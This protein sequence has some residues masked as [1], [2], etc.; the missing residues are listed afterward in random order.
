MC[1]AASEMR[2]ISRILLV[3]TL[4][5]S[6][7]QVEAQSSGK[8]ESK[9]DIKGSVN[10]ETQKLTSLVFNNT[11][12]IRVLLP[13]GYH[14]PKNRETRYPVLYLNDGVMVF[15]AFDIEKTVH[16]LIKARSIPPMVVVGIDNGGSTNTTKDPIADRANEFLP[17]PDVGFAPDN[18]YEPT[19][20]N[21]AGKKYP[22]FLSEVISLAESRYR[23][24]TGPA[25]TGIGGF[26]YGG[27]AAIYAVLNR[28]GPFGK[29]LIESTPLWI[30]K[31]K[32]FMKDIESST[33]WPDKIYVG[34]GTRESPE[35]AVNKEGRSDYDRFL[36]IL[37]KNAANSN[38]QPVL[39]KDARHAPS[40]WA[41]RF[42]GAL[43]FLFGDSPISKNERE[44]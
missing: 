2:A 7:G 30:G 24:K 32:Q 16:D 38:V 43:K 36:A 39:E 29:L 10:L 17:Y 42:P 11:R 14:E 34:L 23:L 31:D 21:P 9:P 13:P 12:T 5:L 8:N 25:N 6:C 3:V 4:L 22:D 26:S 1:V 19:P 40:Y 18:L 28:N 35:E 37:R 33:K 44:E 15:H 41:K 20:P 27:V